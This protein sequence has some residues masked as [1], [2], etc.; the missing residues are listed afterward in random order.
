MPAGCL[1]FAGLYGVP[2]LPARPLVPVPAG[3]REGGRRGR[4]A[5]R[6]ASG[7][8]RAGRPRG[9]AAGAGRRERGGPTGGAAAGAFKSRRGRALQALPAEPSGAVGALWLP[10]RLSHAPARHVPALPA[11][12]HRRVPPGAARRPGPPGRAGCSR[13]RQ[14]R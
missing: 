13:R 6:W 4:G 1:P 3:A 2:R 5:T 12:A 7:A 9:G 8:E 10:S 14:E 11:G